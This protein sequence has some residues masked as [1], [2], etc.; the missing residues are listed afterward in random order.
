MTLIRVM[1]TVGLPHIPHSRGVGFVY[2][3]IKCSMIQGGKS[4]LNFTINV[5]GASDESD[6]LQDKR[7]KKWSPACHSIS[8]LVWC[9]ALLRGLI[10]IFSQHVQTVRCSVGLSNRKKFSIYLVTY[11][12]SWFHHTGKLWDL[13]H[14]IL[15]D[16]EGCVVGC[17]EVDFGVVVRAC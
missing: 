14:Q 1:S 8:K 7:L 4:G 15:E 9:Q 5:F 16:T 13:I 12:T 10:R 6:A 3:L 17:P 11:H 2:K